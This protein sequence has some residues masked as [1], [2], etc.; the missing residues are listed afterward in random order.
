ML[1]SELC[2][3]HHHDFRQTT[4]LHTL[5]I[6]QVKNLKIF[7][8]H[9]IWAIYYRGQLNSQLLIGVYS[10]HSGAFRFISFRAR[11]LSIGFPRPA[12]S[13]AWSMPPCALQCKT[14]N[15]MIYDLIT[16]KTNPKKWSYNSIRLSFTFSLGHRSIFHIL[17]FIH[18]TMLLRYSD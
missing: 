7:T 9:N 8:L 12:F 3:V 6:D 16:L 13:A 15:Q 2:D 4:M 14:K 10:K 1:N 18:E 11:R 5:Y 17:P